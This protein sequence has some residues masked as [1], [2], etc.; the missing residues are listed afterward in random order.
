MKNDLQTETLRQ[1]LLA[2]K[3]QL[4]EQIKQERGGL[5]GRSEVASAQLAAAEQSHAQNITERDTAFAIQEH[6][7]AELSAIEEALD[8]ITRNAYGLCLDCDQEIPITRL[9]A[10]PA[11]MRCIACQA[12]A[13]RVLG[14]GANLH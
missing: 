14:S 7:L 1:L 11:A 6:N 10:F 13:E 5:V 3:F 9:L 2:Q 8:R 4:I 12:N